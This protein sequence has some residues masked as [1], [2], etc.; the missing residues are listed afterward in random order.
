MGRQAYRVKDARHP[1]CISKCARRHA[2]GC[3]V[4]PTPNTDDYKQL[5]GLWPRPIT[6]EVG[7]DITAEEWGA[8]DILDGF[9]PL[10][11]K[12]TPGEVT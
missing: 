10:E 12:Q 7:G 6:C 4:I 3:H 8:R 2:R 11:F 9:S 1:L 5:A